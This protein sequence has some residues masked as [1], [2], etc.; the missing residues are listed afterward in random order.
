MIYRCRTVLSLLMAAL[1]LCA[2]DVWAD[3]TIAHESDS[4]STPHVNSDSIPAPE[5]APISTVSPDSIQAQA[6]E[7]ASI[8]P[9]NN[10]YYES[11]QLELRRLRAELDSVKAIMAFYGV[12]PYN[13]YRF[14]VKTDITFEPGGAVTMY[15]D[16]ETA[17]DAAAILSLN[18]RFSR[19]PKWPVSPYLETNIGVWSFGFY[20]ALNAGVEKTFFY[21][22]GLEI[23]P[24]VAVQA[25][26]GGA[27]EG[28]GF[29]GGNTLVE[30]ALGHEYVTAYLITGLRFIYI[31]YSW[32]DIFM[33]SVPLG[34]GML[35]KI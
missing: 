15:R 1:L 4:T 16:E 6:R 3:D 21:R 23:T 14:T 22:G 8:P 17:Y 2:A 5:P 25:G 33:L 31:N 12:K 32:K 18:T 26:I 10:E 24:S 29:T 9:V 34:V 20:L 30:F 11:R 27:F 19:N 28:F 13:A 35:I 7:S